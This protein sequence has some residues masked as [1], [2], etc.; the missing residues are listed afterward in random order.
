MPA[1]HAQTLLRWARPIAVLLV[2]CWVPALGFA[3]ALGAEGAEGLVRQHWYEGIPKAEVDRIDAEGATHLVSMLADPVEREHHANILIAL[4]QCGQ[5]G[6]YEAIEAFASSPPSGEVDRAT[7]RAWQV[8]PFA[9]GH[10]AESDRRAIDR[11]A[12]TL[13]AQSS[14]WT[15]R[16]FDSARVAKLNRR[17]AVTSLAMTGLPEARAHLVRKSRAAAEPDF[18]AH[19]QEAMGVHSQRALERNQ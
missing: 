10:L 6:A 9:W 19:V 5:P 18:A 2:L 3:Q 12:T 17:A 15:F 16:N 14:G 11:L 13:D 8:L 7:F 4:S 1:R